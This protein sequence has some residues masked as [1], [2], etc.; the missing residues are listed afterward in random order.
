[1]KITA[2]R[3]RK[4]KASSC[5][6]FELLEESLPSIPEGS[7][8]AITSKVASL[9][10][11][12]VVPIESGVKDDI[13]EQEADY[14]LPKS[15]NKYDVY[16]TIKHNL[17]VPSSGVDE[18]NTDGYYVKW[19]QDPQETVNKCWELLRDMFQ[20]RNLGVILTDSTCSPLRWGVSGKCIAYCGFKGVNSKVGEADL[21]GRK[22]EMTR[23]NVADALA[24]AAVLCMGES[25]EQTPIAVIA[26]L[27]F[28][29]YVQAPPT[30]DEIKDL[31]ID[32]EDDLFGQL[33]M[34]V[35]WQSVKKK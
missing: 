31:Q 35:N 20:I 5:S 14:F 16:L 8:V 6:I 12:N 25:D 32:A 33:L 28:V 27:P 13:I 34:A 21:F 7:V 4:V 3:T 9:C 15:G 2:I 24:A 26:D 17:L 29:E 30:L 23:V 1:M 19:P 22:L 10:E 11:G 18:S